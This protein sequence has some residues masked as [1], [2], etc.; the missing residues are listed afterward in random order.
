MRKVNFSVLRKK[1][2]KSGNLTATKISDI[3]EISLILQI[4]NRQYELKQLVLD[5]LTFQQYFKFITHF[6][7]INIIIVSVTPLNALQ[8]SIQSFIPSIN[9]EP[10]D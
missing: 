5:T 8:R 9:F 2:A 3:Q 1:K 7:N 6:Q 10:L 4:K